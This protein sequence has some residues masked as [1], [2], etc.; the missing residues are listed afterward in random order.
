[1]PKEHYEVLLLYDVDG[2]SHD[3][4]AAL[5]DI[6]AVTSRKRLSRAKQWI[7]SRFDVEGNEMILKKSSDYEMD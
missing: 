5:L 2:Y 3:E 6:K 7:V 1:L 4:I